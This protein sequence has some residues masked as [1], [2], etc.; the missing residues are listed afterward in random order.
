MRKL[1]KNER[2]CVKCGHIF[3]YNTKNGGRP[4]KS[5][6]NGCVK[7]CKICGTKFKT[8]SK[9]VVCCSNECKKILKDRQ[10]AHR[11]SLGTPMTVVLSERAIKKQLFRIRNNIDKYYNYS[12]ELSNRELLSQGYCYTENMEDIKQ[13]ID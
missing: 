7:I 2:I 4:P 6:P 9:N 1:A 11:N 10:A 8:K 12:N 3:R 5:C 13:F